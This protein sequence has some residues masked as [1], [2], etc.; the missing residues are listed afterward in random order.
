MGDGKSKK[1]KKDKKERKEKRLRVEVY[2]SEDEAEIRAKRK[3]SKK[4]EKVAKVLGYSNDVNPFGD[5]ELLKPFVWGKKLEQE[6]EDVVTGSKSRIT[7]SEA[8]KSAMSEI[9][10]VRARRIQRDE[11]AK[12]SARLRLEEHRLRESAAYGDWHEQEESF[13]K[14]QV[15]QRT[16]IRIKENREEVID[17]VAKNIILLQAARIQEKESY[18]EYQ[19]AQI[20]LNGRPSGIPERASV[21]SILQNASL[22]ELNDVI[23]CTQQYLSL[24]QK[25]DRRQLNS[26]TETI[27]NAV[28]D[29]HHRTYIDYWTTLS[30]VASAERDNRLR[31]STTNTAGSSS[32][33]SNSNGIHKSVTEDI[34]VLLIGKD[35]PS[36]HKLQQEIDDDI[37]DGSK[38][39]KVYW[40]TMSSEIGIHIARHH[41]NSLN[42]EY[43]KDYIK[44]RPEIINHG[45]GVSDGSQ[46]NTN[47][48]NV[49]ASILGNTDSSSGEYME[50]HGDSLESMQIE[51]EVRLAKKHYSWQDKY[52][53][54]KPRYI[55]KVKTG[56]DWNRYNSTHYDHDNPPPRTVQGYHFTIFY[57]DLLQKNNTPTYYLEA[58]PNTPE[59]ALLRFHVDGGPYEDIAFKILNKEWDVNKKAGFRVTFDKGVLNLQF[60]F[61]R[62]FYRR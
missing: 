8:S 40:G 47:S 25:H 7:S 33:D 56:W 45:V 26:S 44:L 22:D 10:S 11:E 41:L 54:R 28:S 42:E 4:I 15:K 17:R 6:K 24:Q 36:L 21:I 30:I 13:H 53:P 55:N 57:P 60:N 5:S 2:D 37:A 49:G 48:S 52:R 1:E 3:A 27:D 9:E 43:I 29:T 32:T 18:A 38:V 23:Q 59:F 19:E 51:E 31:S 46:T 58:T 12:E 50:Q 20:L 35:I 39:D 34:Q 14:K 16:I 61:K 62:A